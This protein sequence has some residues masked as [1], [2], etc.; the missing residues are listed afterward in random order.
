MNNSGNFADKWTKMF[1]QH[2]DEVIE[3]DSVYAQP[4]AEVPE[5][6]GAKL[7]FRRIGKVIY[8]LRKVFMAIPVVYYALKLA[9]YN[10]ENL[11]EMVGIDLQS[12]GEFAQMI[13]RDTAVYGPLAVTA[14]CLALMLVSRKAVYPWIISIF[15]LILPLLLLLTNNYPA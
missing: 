6:T 2:N 11:P 7:I 15:S 13:A 5:K 12:S 9:A 3:E 4:E 1:D 10:M 14:A 8:H